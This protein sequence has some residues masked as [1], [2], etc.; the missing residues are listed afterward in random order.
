MIFYLLLFWGNLS[1]LPHTLFSGDQT[2]RCFGKLL[3]Y[4]LEYIFLRRFPSKP[5]LVIGICCDE[6]SNICI[7]PSFECEPFKCGLIN[8]GRFKYGLTWN[9]RNVSWKQR[10]IQKIKTL[11]GISLLSDV[12]FYA[13]KS[14]SKKVSGLPKIDQNCTY[15]LHT[16]H[17][18]DAGNSPD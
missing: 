13:R 11:D 3:G 6:Q 12:T 15:H 10:M 18:R 17:N 9:G 8:S 4:F 1:P 16:K 2:T 7:L 14:C 5:M